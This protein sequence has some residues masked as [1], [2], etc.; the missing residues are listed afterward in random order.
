M[1]ISSLLVRGNIFR[2]GRMACK[3]LIVPQLP[4]D[5]LVR[6]CIYQTDGILTACL[7][8]CVHSKQ[9][10][11]SSPIL[12]SAP[13]PSG[14]HPY[15]GLSYPVPRTLTLEGRPTPV[16]VNLPCAHIVEWDFPRLGDVKHPPTCGPILY[17]YIY[18]DDDDDNHVFIVHVFNYMYM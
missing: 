13:K 9:L 10:P 15:R 5:N 7:E 12:I 16:D 3:V 11:T 2:L 18:D 8:E 1:S 4:H 17:M 14:H 6:I